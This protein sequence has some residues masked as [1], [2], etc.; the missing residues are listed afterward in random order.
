MMNNICFLLVSII[1]LMLPACK[2]K[3]QDT[4]VE[5]DILPEHTCYLAVLGQDSIAMKIAFHDEAVDG[6]LHYNFFEKDKSHGTINGMLKGDTLFANYSFMAEGVNSSREVVF[7]KTGQGWVEG[8]GEM[9]ST[10]TK[11]KNLAALDFSGKTIL[12][13]TNCQ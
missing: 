10:G 4:R 5:E 11:F 1:L 2:S 13:E 12:K 9:D 8:Y 3:P 6:E 7:L